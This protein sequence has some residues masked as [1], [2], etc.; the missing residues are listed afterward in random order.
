MKRRL[1]T[2]IGLSLTILLLLPSVLLPRR[3]A[4][5]EGPS[6]GHYPKY[7]QT[8]Q[9]PPTQRTRTTSSSVSQEIRRING[10]LAA[11]KRENDSLRVRVTALER[12]LRAATEVVPELRASLESAVKAKA[13]MDS[14]ELTLISQLSLIM[15]KIRLL[16]E[17]AAYIDSTNFEILSQLVLLENKI[18]SLTSSFNDIM[19]ARKAEASPP[20]AALTDEELRFRYVDAI[21]TYQNGQYREAIAKFT[22]LVRDRS[23]HEWA[24]NSQYWLAECFYA[25]GNYK[26]AITEFERVFD[27]KASEKADDSRYKIALCYRNVGSH[28]RA[29]I[30]F[31]KLL[32]E[33]PDSELVEK[34]RRFLQSR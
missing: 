31:Q 16:E 29:R 21:G 15:N 2:F 28:N 7:E 5:P 27:Y 25:L 18:V 11:L 6:P 33:Y 17:K 10:R 26:Q 34:A 13:A 22:D 23:Q 32:D 24:D 9:Q 19:A 20:P 12:N 3:L 30:E 8:Q 1:V 14:S 4:A